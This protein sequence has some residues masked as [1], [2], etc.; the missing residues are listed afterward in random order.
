MFLLHLFFILF[1]TPL[2]AVEEPNPTLIGRASNEG[3]NFISKLG[4]KIVDY[5]IP[6]ITIPEID[7]DIDAGPGK[8]HLI[9]R[10]LYISKFQTP[11]FKFILE[12]PRSIHWISEDGY[13]KAKGNIHVK[14]TALITF[15]FSASINIY[16]SDIR[17]N[18]SI[19]LHHK[20]GRP[21]LDVNYCNTDIKK[22]RLSFGG[23][24]I[25]WIVNL[26]QTPL[27]N[28]ARNLIRKQF[29]DQL[30][31]VLLSEINNLLVEL[32]THI[33]AWKNF[34]INYDY[35]HLPVVTSD[36]VQLDVYAIALMGEDKCPLKVE[37]MDT[38][39]APSNFMGNVWA[40]TVIPNCFLYSVYKE[41]IVKL[42]IN[43]NMGQ[44]FEGLLKTTCRFLEIC[45]GRFF[46]ILREDYPDKYIDIVVRLDKTPN[47]KVSKSDGIV[48]DGIFSLD[49]TISPYKD[50]DKILAR[51]VSET[52]ATLLPYIENGRAKVNVGE[53]NFTLK[54][55]FSNIGNFSTKICDFIANIIKPTLKKTLQTFGK[56]GL[57]IPMFQNFT[58]S[59]TSVLVPIDNGVRLDF[60]LIYKKG[61]DKYLFHH[62]RKFYHLPI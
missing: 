41:Q 61:F 24:T 34:Y 38:S 49:F 28:V 48:F 54:E 37:K 1:L 51:L 2:W 12:P 9:V 21:Q 43:K 45:L 13:I 46:K 53:L 50:G 25:P 42:I 15:S 8:G 29:C 27:S 56:T 57:K 22:L 16:A 40:S 35:N 39:E 30:K 26:F 33:D 18:Y 10:N 23:G 62:L 19:S 7:L 60:D 14:Y 52:N 59:S 11:K 47:L 4:H 58:I 36:Y 6:Q 32:P 17:T 20:E 5:E 44:P 3:L 31:T 55:Q